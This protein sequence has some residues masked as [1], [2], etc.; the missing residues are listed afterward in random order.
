MF[1]SIHSQREAAE[2]VLYDRR[3]HPRPGVTMPG[4][5]AGERPPNYGMKLPAEIL[6]VEE[7]HRLMAACP[8]RGPTGVRNRALIV[9]LWR[10]GL[11]CAE[12]LALELRDIDADQGRVLVRH[13]KG[14]QRRALGLDPPAFA[15]IE[16]W[17]AVRRRLDVQR[18][19]PIF[20]TI[21]NP[22]RGRPLG[23][24]YWRGAIKK[25]GAKAGIEK[26]V[27]SHGLRHTF[28]VE[29]AEEGVPITIISKALGHSSLAVTER[30][31]NHLHPKAVI[32]AM[33]ARDW[34]PE[35]GPLPV[36]TDQR[37]AAVAF[38]RG[39]DGPR[40]D[41]DDAHLGR[42]RRRDDDLAHAASHSHTRKVP[43]VVNL[44][45]GGVILAADRRFD[46]TLRMTERQEEGGDDR[47]DHRRPSPVARSM[48]LS[49]K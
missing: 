8:R 22:V 21:T 44:D 16:Q 9:V 47:H 39:D 30:Y 37:L 40:E 27:H 45:L 29:L 33:R 19:A 17:L 15:V 20:C 32:D 23:A 6:T 26:R 28:A 24:P 2:H 5:K 36:H 34:S 7:V 18:G 35:R 43:A 13:G 25:L 14:N 38:E 1:R 10:A 12:A 42:A 11:R 4:Y 41:R 3:G 49:R 48:R 46:R 31:L